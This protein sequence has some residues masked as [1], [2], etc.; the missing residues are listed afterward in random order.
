M[1]ACMEMKVEIQS[2]FLPSL[3]YLNKVWSTMSK[4]HTGKIIFW[5]FCMHTMRQNDYFQTCLMQYL[6]L[7]VQNFEHVEEYFNVVVNEVLDLVE[8]VV[9]VWWSC[10]KFCSNLMTR[11]CFPVNISFFIPSTLVTWVSQRLLFPWPNRIRR[12]HCKQ[13]LGTTLCCV[14]LAVHVRGIKC[15]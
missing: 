2:W 6:C 5:P 15:S 9:V 4:K 14:L 11:N 1:L 12:L 13:A 10:A 3:S 7:W 8:G